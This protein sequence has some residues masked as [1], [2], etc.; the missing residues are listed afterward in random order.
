MVYGLKKMLSHQNYLQHLYYKLDIHLY[1]ALY[2]QKE[3]QQDKK[4]T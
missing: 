3:I 2:K 1:E 4:I